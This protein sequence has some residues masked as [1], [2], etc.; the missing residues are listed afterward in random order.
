[1][2]WYPA[3]TISVLSHLT[4]C[5]Q[6][7]RGRAG[8]VSDG[9]LR[10]ESSLGPS[11]TLED[12]SEQHAGTFKISSKPSSKAIHVTDHTGSLMLAIHD[13]GT[14]GDFQATGDV[15]VGDSRSTSS[16][17]MSIY[18]TKGSYLDIH[19]G[20]GSNSE[21]KL[22]AGSSST[23]SI[24][25]GSEN[26]TGFFIYAGSSK[27]KSMRIAVPRPVG[28][29][30]DDHSKVAEEPVVDILNI[31]D[32]GR[33][34]DLELSG[35]VLIGS[36]DATK[37]QLR[38][39]SAQVSKLNIQA[40]DFADGILQL[41][42][43]PGK[44]AMVS[45]QNEANVAVQ[46]GAKSTVRAGF[47]I[48][49][50]TETATGNPALY[51]TDGTNGGKDQDGNAVTQIASN[52]MAIYDRGSEG[53]LV[54]TGNGVF[55]DSTADTVFDNT[56]TVRGAP[57]KI[58]VT[59][60]KDDSGTLSIKSGK[61]Q[62]AKVRLATHNDGAYEL[63]NVGE[64]DTR[65]MDVYHLNGTGF[66][67]SIMHLADLGAT[68]QL[69]FVGDV[70]I[71]TSNSSVP[72]RLQVGNPKSSGKA[73]I[74]LQAGPGFDSTLALTSGPNRKSVL[75]LVSTVAGQAENVQ[76]DMLLDGGSAKPALQWMHGATTVMSVMDT[77]AL[78]PAQ[79]DLLSLR[80]ASYSTGTQGSGS[81]KIIFG[82][83]TSDQILINGHIT[84]PELSFD[85]DQ[86]G[87]MLKLKFEDPQKPT[88]IVFPDESG[89]V[90]TSASS[91]CELQRV[92]ALKSGEIVK[93]FGK[94]VTAASIETIGTESQIAS[95]GTFT[96]NS[97]F[98][99]NGN[100]EIGDSIADKV[101]FRGVVQGHFKFKPGEG[102]KFKGKDQKATF[103]KAAFEPTDS[104]KSPAGA[105][106]IMIPDVPQ[107]GSLHIVA[108]DAISGEVRQV[109]NVM[110]VSVDATA[111][112]LTGPQN[113][114][115][116]PMEAVTFHLVNRRIQK[117]SIVLCMVND[118]ASEASG[119]WLLVTAVKV[120]V[121][122]QGCAIVITNINPYV[123]STLPM[124]VTRH[125]FIA[126]A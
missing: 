93:G 25:L 28:A 4:N 24:Q 115:L 17:S 99:A 54:V 16:R 18:G 82:D 46:E 75:S 30:G 100:V 20:T 1:M 21:L 9:V 7:T 2:I 49:I 103:L 19:A 124:Q 47:D 119:G 107:G 69:A 87:V 33:T 59:A 114:A 70:A 15:T 123:S 58:D 106:Q 108:N 23:A 45:L 126:R 43:G 6:L 110:Q 41:K 61:D 66:E 86:N 56:I 27:S 94:I 98:K 113:M 32:R 50:E 8:D 38:V 83:A 105:R 90:L 118:D 34:G 63:I 51:F 62:L 57:G 48:Q 10:L 31:V 55:G 53:D 65:R 3:Q 12:T 11:I 117:K 35:D 88:T 5:P 74:E 125:I 84:N 102:V 26:T 14:E 95:A 80:C 71:G 52:M 112:K 29:H 72:I 13:R 85:G 89:T 116:G 73:Q 81:H 78:N 76:F 60:G 101:T 39:V 120:N 79:V 97:V 96:A 109:S 92:G 122:G 91:N 68:G 36:A 67:T 22:G 42:S 111:G 44:T 64:G 121:G 104:D 77:G 40:G 37:K